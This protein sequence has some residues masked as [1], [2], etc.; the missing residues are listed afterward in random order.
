MLRD[1]LE[2]VD[3]ELDR[4]Q[5]D[6]GLRDISLVVGGEHLAILAEPL[7]LKAP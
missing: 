4:L 5:G 3:S 2:D 6:R 1:R 7:R